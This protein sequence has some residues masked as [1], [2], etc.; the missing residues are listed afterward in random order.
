MKL[1]LETI[2]SKDTWEQ[3]ILSHSPE[4]LFQSWLW[5]EVQKKAGIP[6]FR[7]GIMNGDK[8]VGIAQTVVVRARRGTFLHVRHGPIWVEQKKEYWQEFLSLFT[9]LARKEKAWF[10]RVSPLVANS[11]EFRQLFSSMHLVPASVHEVDAERCWVLDLDKTE[12]E[13]LMGMRKTTRYEIRRAQKMGVI[14]K[15][16]ADAKDLTYFQTLYRA[17]SQRHRFVAHTAIAEEF[18]IF[19]KEKK[20]LLFLGF[21]GKKTVA[22]AIILFYGNQAIYHHGASVFSK[23]PVS[24]LVQW[25]SIREAQKRG[26]KLYNFYGIAPDDKPNHPWRGITLFKKGF[27]GREINYIHAQDFAVSPLYVIP[28]TIETMRRRFRGY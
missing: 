26:I 25:E 28:R 8:L 2:N 10:I 6:V 5:G 14:V 21:D 23:V 12:D 9:S 17:T 13:L 4:A 3:F 19:A 1:T 15:K 7:F 27:G 20:A 18:E 22:S 24:Y 11:Q 16:S